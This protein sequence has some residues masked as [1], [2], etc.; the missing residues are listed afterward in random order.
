M[1]PFATLLLV[2][3]A[4]TAAWAQPFNRVGQD[5]M[6]ARD[7][8]AATIAVDG[9]LNDA[10]WAQAET[11]R[12]RWNDDDFPFPG[13]GR[14]F[15]LN[16]AGL[17]FNGNPDPTDATVS[18]LR[19]GNDLYLGFNVPDQS[20]GG[21][22]NLFRFDGVMMTLINKS[23]RPAT[24]TDRRNYFESSAVREEMVYGW[25]IPNAA[26]TSATGQP[27]AGLGPRAWST[28]FGL[29]FGDPTNAEP[30][31]PEAWEY[32]AVVNG[33]SGDDFNGN[34]TLTPDVGYTM[35][36]RIRLDSLGWNLT[37]PMARMPLT[38]AVNDMDYA[39][40]QDAQRYNVNRTWWQGRWL[41]NLN[42]GVAYVAGDPGVTVTSGAAPAYTQPEFTVPAGRNTAAP[43]IDGR[44]DERAWE[45]TDPQFTLQYQA[46]ANQLDAVLPG[47]LA[48][49]YTFYFSPG[50][51]ADKPILDPS[52]GKIK[53]FYKGSKLYLGLDSDDQAV[54]GRSGEAGDGFRLQIRSR[55]ST[56]AGL[57]ETARH[58]RMD[59]SIDSTGA[60][61]FT[62]VAQEI[63]DANALKAAVS[64]K[65]GSTAANP[66]DIDA[67]YQMEVELDL[68]AI[69]YGGDLDATG[70]QIYIALNYFDA[71]DLEDD[72]KSYRTVTW[73]VGERVNG[74]SVY[75]L[76]DPNTLVATSGE[77]GPEAGQLRFAGSYPNP[78][79]GAAT[80]RYELD[81]EATVTVE[82]FDVLGRRVQVLETGPQ[83]PGSRQV[84]IDGR[85]LSAG[86]YLVRVRLGD[87]TSVS[88]RMMIVR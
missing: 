79:T 39:W 12:I 55:D 44:L 11:Y 68:A 26:D 30:R 57:P 42:E 34:P 33:V 36:M 7:I 69:G 64:L 83:A 31:S 58:L 82:V 21:S 4:A 78:T 63:L 18:F 2:L 19:K 35:E 15:D 74:A 56:I 3:A 16:P 25:F 46:S 81:R 20:I 76:L 88:G 71:D 87:G 52:V 41:N 77:G 51:A 80:L 72:A 67:G 75:G 66:T 32:A 8:G 43:T 59:F 28:D 5:V 38:I 1:K 14:W 22:R 40:P 73:V 10:V 48:P 23:D 60:A 9:N 85:S 49:V 29:R 24:F 65:A 17:D 84:E 62:N 13:G 70:A 54:S 37:Q 27:K 47:V 86:S 6:W 61:R 53:M 50:N 45:V